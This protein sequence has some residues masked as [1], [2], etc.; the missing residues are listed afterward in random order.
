MDR[1]GLVAW[2]RGLGWSLWLLCPRCS[3]IVPWQVYFESTGASNRLSDVNHFWVYEYERPEGAEEWPVIGEVLRCGGDVW[4]GRVVGVS[5]R[6][7]AGRD[8]AGVASVCRLRSC[9]R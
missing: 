1:G 4:V 5:R 6:G 8:C 3:R 7:L 9:R 2:R